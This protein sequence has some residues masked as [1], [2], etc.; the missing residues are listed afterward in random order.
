MSHEEGEALAA[1]YKI[2]FIE[3]SA[4]SNVNVNEAFM[5]IAKLVY[6]RIS[7]TDSKPLSG[8]KDDK[9]KISAISSDD[10]NGKKTKKRSWCSII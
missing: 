8:R 6:T 9:R 10:F 5:T 4:V 7:T 2:P 3:T 1:E